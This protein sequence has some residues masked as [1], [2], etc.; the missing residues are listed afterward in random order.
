MTRAWMTEHRDSWCRKGWNWCTTWSFAKALLATIA[1]CCL[2]H[3]CESRRTSTLQ[4]GSIW[5]SASHPESK[6]TKSQ[7]LGCHAPKAIWSCQSKPV[8]LYPDLHSSRHHNRAA[9]ASL[10]SPT[11]EIEYWVRYHWHIADT[12]TNDDRWSH[13]DFTYL[14]LKLTMC[15]Y[16]KWMT[17][18]HDWFDYDKRL[19]IGKGCKDD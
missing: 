17:E 15:A 5:N 18:K 14:S 7:I 9:T 16:G 12:W 10:G 8:I 1:T 2:G 4:T 3:G 13:P 11:V 6:I 19:R